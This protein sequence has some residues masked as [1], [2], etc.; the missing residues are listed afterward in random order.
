M[1]ESHHF[2][3]HLDNVSMHIHYLMCLWVLLRRKSWIA[4]Y[5]QSW[6][7]KC[8]RWLMRWIWID[9]RL[10]EAKWWVKYLPGEFALCCFNFWWWA[11]LSPIKSWAILKNWNWQLR[12]PMIIIP[13]LWSKEYDVPVLSL[14][15]QEHMLIW[16]IK[17]MI[18]QLTKGIDNCAVIAA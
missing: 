8:T 14:E 9:V 12:V 1:L 7:G 10:M 15:M 5:R 16:S 4:P 2:C 6:S 11:P 13:C 17:K 18:K 3:T